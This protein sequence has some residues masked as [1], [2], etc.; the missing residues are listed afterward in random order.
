MSDYCTEGEYTIIGEINGGCGYEWSILAVV[1]HPGRDAYF[2][3][4]DAGCSCNYPYEDWYPRPW[5]PGSPPISKLEAIKYIN[6]LRTDNVDDDYRLEDYNNLA[7][8]VREFDPLT[9]N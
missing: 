5:E 1:Y 6:N 9:L 8:K 7:Q 4:E 2:V 3:Y